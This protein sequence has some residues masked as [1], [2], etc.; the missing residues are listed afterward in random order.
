MYKIK[1]S[2]LKAKHVRIEGVNRARMEQ[3]LE[4]VRKETDPK[5]K[6][7]QVVVR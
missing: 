7:I 1:S 6:L 5:A 2:V 4:V 3:R